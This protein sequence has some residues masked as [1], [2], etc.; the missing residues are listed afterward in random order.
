MKMELSNLIDGL[1]QDFEEMLS[2]KDQAVLSTQY[3]PKTTC[4]LSPT[5]N[6]TA[7]PWEYI[8]P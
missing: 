6:G 3:C 8:G 4:A 7:Y 1:Y 5:F 2:E